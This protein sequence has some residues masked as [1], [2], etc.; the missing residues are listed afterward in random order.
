MPVKTGGNKQHL[1][2]ELREG[3]QPEFAH[4]RAEFFAAA[5]GGQRDID[6]ALRTSPHAAV[7]IKWMLESGN[8]QYAWIIA[9][10]IFGAI[11][12]MDVEIRHRD[13]FQSIRLHGVSNSHRNI[14]KE[15]ESH[16]PVT[17]G[18]MAWWANAAKSIFDISAHHQVDRQDNRACSTI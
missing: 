13:A 14:I 10:N 8:H 12:V 17:F 3:R 1:W 7:W 5:A 4:R 9:K 16:C 15:T 11:A 2:F 6:H 18:M